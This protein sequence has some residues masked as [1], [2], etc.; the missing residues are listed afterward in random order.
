[1]TQTDVHSNTRL[2]PS[3]LKPSL[4]TQTF[5]S[6]GATFQTA[7]QVKPQ[8]LG[9]FMPPSADDPTADIKFGAGNVSGISL[10][11]R[12]SMESM[13]LKRKMDDL[14]DKSREVESSSKKSKKDK[15]AKKEKKSKK[16]KKSKRDEKSKSSMEILTDT[17]AAPPVDAKPLHSSPSPASPLEG[18]VTTHRG[19]TLMVLLDKTKEIVYSMKRSDVGELIPIGK[20]MNGSIQI[21]DSEGN[22]FPFPVDT[23]DHCESPK[24]S[25]KDIKPILDHLAIHRAKSKNGLAIYDPYYCDGSVKDHLADIGYT[26]VHNK[27]EDA[28]RT[29]DAEDNSHPYPDYDLFITNPPYSGDH[30]EKMME[31]LTRDPRS[32]GKP[33]CLLMPNYVHKKDYYK[34][35]LSKKG[36][37]GSS[38][39]IQPFY[40]VPK[41]RYIY[42]PPKNFREKKQSDVH[43]KSSPFVSMWYIWGGSI[44]LTEELIKAYKRDG[45]KTCEIARSVS[46]LRDLRRK[47]KNKK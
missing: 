24:N 41:K 6:W 38:R 36:R 9:V 21:D 14:D 4:P 42:L 7:A 15:K 18:Q 13:S 26:N 31:H 43:K 37:K 25:Y 5:T 8:D 44:E 20:L 28:Y 34:N 47:G 45:E 23:D 17:V 10:I 16:D 30:P 39:C 32:C 12:Q 40:L 29:W 46:A 2:P 11:A 19:E 27:R 3:N 22:E 35:L 33:W 1:M